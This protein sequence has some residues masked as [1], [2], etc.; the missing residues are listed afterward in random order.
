[1]RGADVTADCTHV[2]EHPLMLSCACGYLSRTARELV[3]EQLRRAAD[4]LLADPY[5]RRAMY[6]RADELGGE[7]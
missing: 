3:A 1:M 2:D 7:R 5:E 6:E 4:D